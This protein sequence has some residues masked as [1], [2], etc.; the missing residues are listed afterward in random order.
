LKFQGS[1]GKILALYKWL[2]GIFRQHYNSEILVNRRTYLKGIVAV[3]TV[4]AASFSIFKWFKINKPIDVKI[5]LKSE[6]IIA[7]LV[8]VIIPETDTP[9]ARSASVHKYIIN[10][11]INCTSV[12]QQNK[13]LSGI[14]DLKQYAIDKYE[15]EFLNCSTI[16]KNAVLEYFAN[17][18]GY[19]V[20]I[21]NKINNKFLGEPFYSRLRN[22]TVEG[23]CLSKLGAMEGLAYDYIPGTYAACIPLKPNQKSWATK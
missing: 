8:D 19:S 7:H 3:S 10:V 11:M 13:F 21:L 22:L 14:E 23:Y 1:I 17:N 15:K 4:G 2:L 9:G 16:E 6:E 12:N 5:L 20:N 18:S